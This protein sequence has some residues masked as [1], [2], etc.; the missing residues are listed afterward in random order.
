MFALNVAILFAASL[1]DPPSSLPTSAPS[2]PSAFQPGIRIDWQAG[3]VLVDGGIAV[4]NGP[5]EFAACFEGKE[6]ESIVRLKASATHLYMALG[7]IGLT[8]GHPPQWE[9]EA[10]RFVPPAGDLVELFIQYEGRGGEAR[11]V[12]IHEWLLEREYDRVA[13]WRPWVFGGSVPLRDGGIASDRTGAGAALVHLPDSLLSISRD[14]SDKNSELWA[15]ANSPAIPTDAKNV[16]V[17]FRAASAQP[18]A[19]FLD[20]RGDAYV[21]DRFTPIVDLADAILTH[22]RISTSEIVQIE[23]RGVLDADVASLKERLIQLGVRGDGFEVVRQSQ[24][25][26]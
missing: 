6:H 13:P 9:D 18:I 17:V 24:P 4:R 3:E 20:F 21:N 1:V 2:G 12:A 15:V 16:A 10:Q 19:V 23:A 7:L 5:L 26:R 8:P 25:A 14:F 22:R 11:R